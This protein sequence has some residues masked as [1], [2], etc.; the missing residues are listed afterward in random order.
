MAEGWKHKKK[1]SVK[2]TA[3]R[4]SSRHRRS[5]GGSGRKKQKTHDGLGRRHI[6]TLSGHQF[7]DPSSTLAFE[8]PGRPTKVIH[9]NPSHYRMKVLFYET[10]E[11]AYRDKSTIQD[12]A[13]DCDQLN[14]VIDQEGEMNDPQLLSLADHVKVFAGEAWSLIHKR[15]QS[16]GWY[17]DPSDRVAENILS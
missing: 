10:F 15:R 2:R 17:D 13:G 14:V 7:S 8:R 12:T 9:R 4:K 6:H 16:D 11:A 3:D 1:G 5:R